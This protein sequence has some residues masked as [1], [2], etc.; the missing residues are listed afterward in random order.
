[1]TVQAKDLQDEWSWWAGSNDECFSCGPFG[2]KEDAIAE[3]VAQGDVYEADEPGDIIVEYVHVIETKGTFYDCD[4]C[5]TVQEACDGCKSSLEQGE[6]TFQFKQ[7][8]NADC[9]EVGRG[10]IGETRTA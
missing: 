2:T 8:R 6:A 9:V 4:E 7:V 1:M 3:A 10:K 5:G